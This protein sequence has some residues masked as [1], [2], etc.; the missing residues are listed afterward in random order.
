LLEFAR[1]I[2]YYQP[3]CGTVYQKFRAGEKK[4]RTKKRGKKTVDRVDEE[5]DSDWQVEQRESCEAGAVKRT[6]ARALSYLE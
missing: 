2:K 3:Y 4:R 6:R 1:I 5:C